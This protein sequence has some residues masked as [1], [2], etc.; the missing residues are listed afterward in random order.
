WIQCRL[1]RCRLVLAQIQLQRAP[2]LRIQRE[3]L[4]AVGAAFWTFLDVREQLRRSVFRIGADMYACLFTRHGVSPEDAVPS[5]YISRSL[6]RARKSLVSTAGRVKPSS[7]AIS[8]VENPPSTCS[9]RG[10]LYSSGSPR[11]ARRRSAISGSLSM[12]ASATSWPDTSS[13]T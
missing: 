8:A 1:G 7:L 9:T 12:S 13:S 2:D 4:V 10:S 11:I 5:P 3:H 6:L